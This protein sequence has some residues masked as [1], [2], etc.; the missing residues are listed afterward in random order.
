MRPLSPVV[1]RRFATLVLATIVCVVPSVAN[2]GPILGSFTA[3]LSE[4]GFPDAVNSGL[5]VD[6]SFEIAFGDG[7]EIGGL[8]FDPEY[9]NVTSNGAGTSLLYQIYGGGDPHS[10]AG[11]SHSWDP[12]TTLEFSDFV[13]DQAATLTSVTVTVP[14]GVVGAGGGNLVLNTDYSFT[15]NSLLIDLGSVGVSNGGLLGQMLFNLNFV[16]DNPTDP[17]DPPNPVPDHA[18][19]LMLLSAGMAAIAAHRQSARRRR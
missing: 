16:A 5:N 13:L 2:A 9:I 19:S 6:G 11:Y 15:G 1:F 12:G 17:P 8:F 3:T 18:S 10:V 14:F 7:S 4:P